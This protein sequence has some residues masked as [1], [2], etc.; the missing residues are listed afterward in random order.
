MKCF[1]AAPGMNSLAKAQ[2]R[3]SS[4]LMIPPSSLETVQQPLPSLATGEAE[5]LLGAL[6]LRI[7]IKIP[8]SH[9]LG[10]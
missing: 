2:L 9:T 1:I 10:L 5:Q 4:V 6:N 8:V 3:S 7:Y